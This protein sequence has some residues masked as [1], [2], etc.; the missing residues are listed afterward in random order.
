[1]LGLAALAT[2]ASACGDRSLDPFDRAGPAPAPPAV[3]TT[4][5]G[6]D[7]L[8]GAG[9]EVRMARG[10]WSTGYMQAAIFRTLLA[11]L[12]YSVSDP[13]EA[14]LSPSDFYPALARGEYDFWA[15]GWFPNHDKFIYAED[16]ELGLPEGTVVGDHARRVGVQVPQGGLQGILVDRSTADELGVTSMADVAANP[17][18][19][20]SDG[21]GLAE[22]AGCTEGW[23]CHTVIDTI[24]ESNGWQDSIEQ[25]AGDY[26]TLWDEQI[27]RLERGEPVL[28]FTWAPSAY[29]VQLTPGDNAYWLAVP[30]TMLGQQA[31]AA[32]PES[33]CPTQP[34]IMGFTPAD[35]SVVANNEFLATNPAAEELLKQVTIDVLDI[36]LQNLRYKGGE[37]TEAD[38][39]VHAAAW[40]VDNRERVDGWLT[41]ARAAAG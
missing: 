30:R 25:I 12:G 22:L 24:I 2:V 6:P 38:V 32:L 33:Q 20:D 11:E 27:G 34:C 36:A 29:I 16:P 10:N 39:A 4:E 17:T 13:A 1:M 14:E 28:A 31:P 26:D 8:P 3:E 7:R 9:V 21:N 40:I 37:D 5:V 23:A 15:N 41:A 18:P 19:W 35:I